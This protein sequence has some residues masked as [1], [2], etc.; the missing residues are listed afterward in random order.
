MDVCLNDDII[1]WRSRSKSSGSQLQL[2]PSEQ[3]KRANKPL[4]EKRRR[5]RINR[6]LAQLRSILLNNHTQRDQ[7]R[8]NEKSHKQSK[9]EKADILEMTVRHFQMTNVIGETGEF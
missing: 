8:G 2:S 5:A 9:L 4:M 1:K 6:S 3:A 7:R